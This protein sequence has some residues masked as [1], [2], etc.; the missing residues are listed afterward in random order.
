MIKNGLLF[1]ISGIGTTVAILLWKNLYST[2][3][4]IGS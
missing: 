4:G 1:L 2:E 3:N